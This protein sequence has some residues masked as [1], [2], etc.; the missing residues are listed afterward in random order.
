MGSKIKPGVVHSMTSSNECMIHHSVSVLKHCYWK[1]D[2]SLVDSEVF[3][4]LRDTES[5]RFITL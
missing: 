1:V 2:A 3:W 4:M 5:D